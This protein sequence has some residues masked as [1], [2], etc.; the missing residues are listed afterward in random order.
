[1]LTVSIKNYRKLPLTVILVFLFAYTSTAQ[2]VAIGADKMNVFYIGVDNPVSIAESNSAC[3][4][5]IIRVV[6]GTI[7][8]RDCKYVVRCDAIANCKIFVSSQK[9]K[10]ITETDFRVKMIPKP[11]FKIASYGNHFVRA[12]KK[13]IAAQDYVRADLENFD[14][15]LRYYID[16]FRVRIM[17]DSVNIGSYVNI[18][19]KIG[20]P[21]HDAF[22]KLAVG[23]V[24][25]FDKIIAHAPAISASIKKYYG[26]D[27]YD[28]NGNP[29]Y[30]STLLSD[31]YL[32]L[33]LE[34]ITLKVYE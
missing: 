5:L 30:D 25:V 28:E 29:V 24:I 20:Q 31:K 2:T 16:S 33:E 11:F 3:E 12:I 18:S 8:G 26:P 19:N 13:E 27:S 4:D 1:M 17:R 23:D 14:F 7:T 22:S 6:N 9:N 32:I 15:D 34:P 21:L 10:D